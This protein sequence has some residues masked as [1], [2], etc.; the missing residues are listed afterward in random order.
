MIPHA[1]QPFKTSDNAKKQRDFIQQ[2]P[3]QWSIYTTMHLSIGMADKFIVLENG[4]RVVIK[5]APL[6]SAALALGV[7]YGSLNEFE[8]PETSGSAHFFEH[9]LFKGTKN[10]T[11]KQQSEECRNNEIYKDANTDY[12]RIVY[13][14]VSPGDRF[15]VCASLL[16]DMVKNAIL[17]ED[18]LE[19]ERTVIANEI[20]MDM[21]DPD[22]TLKNHTMSVLFKGTPP[23]LPVE[24]TLKSVGKIDREKLMKIYKSSHTPDNSVLVGYGDIDEHKASKILSDYFSDYEGKSCIGKVDFDAPKPAVKESILEREELSQTHGR[25][26]FIIPAEDNDEKKSL[27]T[28]T[29]LSFI[30]EDRLFDEVREKNG[31]VYDIMPDIDAYSKFGVFHIDFASDPSKA[32]LVRSLSEKELENIINGNVEKSEL[33]RAK[34]RYLWD[35]KLTV[36]MTDVYVEFLAE[37]GVLYNEIS[38]LDSL[39]SSLEP[40]KVE[41]I[42]DAADRYLNPDDGVYTAVVPKPKA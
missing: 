14:M 6:H 19:L 4:L 42:I 23:S 25:I 12:D 1:R 13:Y 33:E 39:L 20:A 10:R 17:P 38:S 18:E 40:I 37:E 22:W 41:D 24:G 30:L 32:E 5:P 7:A 26:N 11:W 16:S 31:L 3:P 28:L 8:H 15:E 2:T 29:S 35:R 21:D 9:M 34:R 36:D 27:R